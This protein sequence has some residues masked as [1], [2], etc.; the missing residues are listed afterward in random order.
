M[1][2]VECRGWKSICQVLDVRDRK[3]ARKILEGRRINGQSILQFEGRTPV[4]S[5]EALRMTMLKF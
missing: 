2:R 1:G 3:T 4:V 5:L